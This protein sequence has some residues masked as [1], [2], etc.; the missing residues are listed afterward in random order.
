MLIVFLISAVSL[1]SAPAPAVI[2]EIEKTCPSSNRFYEL[3]RLK[4]LAEL[5][6]GDPELVRAAAAIR[7]IAEESLAQARRLPPES[8]VFK[9]GGCHT[10]DSVRAFLF[11][12]SF[13]SKDQMEAATAPFPT[14]ARTLNAYS[15]RLEEE[16]LTEARLRETPRYDQGLRNMAPADGSDSEAAIAY[17]SLL[18]CTLNRV[19]AEKLT[20]LDIEALMDTRTAEDRLWYV[21]WLLAQHAD[22][23]PSLQARV[24]DLLAPFKEAGEPR[25][26]YYAYL[27]DRMAVNSGRP[28]RYGTQFCQGPDGPIRCVIEDEAALQRRRSLSALN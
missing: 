19:H 20:Q 17:R 14:A 8:P 13:T 10:P 9:Y 5:A 12:A 24:L 15:S 16:G 18:V 2:A 28:Q 6:H 4:C 23:T 21:V 1:A 22:D 26:E 25:S 3:G 7:D 11:A 27:F